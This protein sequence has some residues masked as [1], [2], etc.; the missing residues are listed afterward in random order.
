MFCCEGS[1]DEYVKLLKLKLS[2]ELDL[3]MQK[4]GRMCV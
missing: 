2:L 4:A 3:K 1:W